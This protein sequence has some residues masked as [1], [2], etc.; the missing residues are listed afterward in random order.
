MKWLRKHWLFV[1]IQIALV[2][3]LSLI[4]DPEIKEGVGLLL[5]SYWCVFVSNSVNLKIWEE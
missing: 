1:A 2:D 5:V 3:L 4:S